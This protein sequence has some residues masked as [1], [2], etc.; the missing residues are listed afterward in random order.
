MFF[1]HI[2]YGCCN[3]IRTK[4]GRLVHSC[5]DLAI[6]FYSHNFTSLSFRLVALNVRLT[7]TTYAPEVECLCLQFE[8]FS[9]PAISYNPRL[10][11][12]MFAKGFEIKGK[13]L[14]FLFLSPLSNLKIFPSHLNS[15]NAKI[16]FFY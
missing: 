13:I 3:V 5:V 8:F 16:L 7:F 6:D 11:C 14:F 10:A 9:A 12:K 4:C 15:L 1:S 2:V